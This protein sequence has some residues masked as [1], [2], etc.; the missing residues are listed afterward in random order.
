MAGGPSG[1]EDKSESKCSVSREESA[2]D[3]EVEGKTHRA[4]EPSRNE[5]RA[6]GGSWDW[7][8][9]WRFPHRSLIPR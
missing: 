1:F 5:G 6:P 4:E 3:T 2:V 8:V 9:P 7:L